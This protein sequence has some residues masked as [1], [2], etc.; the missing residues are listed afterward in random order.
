MS[1]FRKITYISIGI[2]GL[3][4]GVYAIRSWR[5]PRRGA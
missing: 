4:A 1:L 2:A 5:R 3:I